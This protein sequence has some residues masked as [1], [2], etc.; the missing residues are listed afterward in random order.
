MPIIFCC[1]IK[2]L[3]V[4]NL[5]FK[6]Q[7]IF[8][9]FFCSPWPFFSEYSSNQTMNWLE[10]LDSKISIWFWLNSI[11]FFF[12]LFKVWF[13]RNIAEKKTINKNLSKRDTPLLYLSNKNSFFDQDFLILNS[14]KFDWFL[15]L[16]AFYR[17][18]SILSFSVD[19]V[20]IF[21][22]NFSRFY[23]RRYRVDITEQIPTRLVVWS[24]MINSYNQTFGYLRL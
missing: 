21:D 20:R 16:V 14:W 18:T 24:M 19:R 11:F 17:S 22:R 5:T 1:S 4:W 23:W 3:I 10:R 15:A 7:F 9:I 6:F 2:N 8:I 12:T 13:M